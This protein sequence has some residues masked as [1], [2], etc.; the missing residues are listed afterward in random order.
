MK[1]SSKISVKTILITKSVVLSPNNQKTN[2]RQ[3]TVSFR[4]KFLKFC[5]RIKTFVQI[6]E[7]T[8]FFAKLG[9]C[10][11]YCKN[12]QKP[13]ENINVGCANFQNCPQRSKKL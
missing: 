9:R 12:T 5:L 3:T 11:D 8:S 6:L 10:T 1:S 4:S 2:K 7:K 13:C